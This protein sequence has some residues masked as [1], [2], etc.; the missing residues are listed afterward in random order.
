[1]S[2]L[3]N[4]LNGLIGRAVLKAVDDARGLQT[5]QI[6]LMADELC[7]DAE[8]VQDYGFA[9]HPHADA[10]AVAIHPGG[11]RSHALVI[12]V[13]D[14]RYRLRNMA[15]G[16]VALYDD[17]GQV[18][19]L[20]RDGMAIESPFKVDLTAPQ[21]TVTAD[22]VDLGGAGGPAVARVGDTVAG[23]VITSGSA[24]VRAA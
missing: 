19:R 10:E 20:K 3:L 14:R 8:R 24:K 4:R 23:G 17:L 2:A 9:S 1:M 12:A 7:P 18:V 22:H 21:V 15:A 5:L 16:E 11:L 6:E 13:A